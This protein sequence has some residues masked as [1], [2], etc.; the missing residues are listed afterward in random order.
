MNRVV[1]QACLPWLALLLAACLVACLLAR[2][3]GG[4]LRLG[5]LRRLHCDQEGAVQSLSFVLTLPLFIMV[6]LFIVQI[7][8]LM[9]G[10][11]VLHYAAYAA[12]RSAAVWIPARMAVPE[13]ENRIS[14]YSIDAEAADQIVP[15]LDPQDEHYGPSQGGVAYSVE[16]GGPKYDKIR[17]AAVLACLPVSPSR[18][19]GDQVPPGTPG[20]DVLPAVYRALAP[21]SESGGAV[22]RRIRNKL[23][24]TLSH[25]QVEV[26]FYHKNEE[27]P[28]APYLL[29][30]DPGEFYVNEIGWQ[31]P[32]T[33][34][35]KYKLALLPGPGRLLAR[36]VPGP[37][38]ERDN[39]SETIQQ[40]GSTYVYPL[41]ASAT[42]GNEG[43][44]SVVPY[45]YQAN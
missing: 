3:S 41:Q 13:G 33:V 28:L 40:E 18:D 22:P 11:M 35:L 26:R 4:K 37:H 29:E 25:L 9:I 24:Y 17:W 23:A 45:V 42:V 32:I 16:P 39:I 19:L 10:T 36:Y 31:D 1:L 27:P 21:R 8:Q 7:S 2:A 15:I 5:R 43:E 30:D 34:T 20:A 12:A 6:M 38:G 14:S 44:K